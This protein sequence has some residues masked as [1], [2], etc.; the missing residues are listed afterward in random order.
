MRQVNE[1]SE[2]DLLEIV[3]EELF[4]Q[5]SARLGKEPVTMNEDWQT[6]A[7]R[8]TVYKQFGDCILGTRPHTFFIS[9]ILDYSYEILIFPV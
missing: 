8:T 9:W 4:E 6:V 5:P 7:I 2:G 3:Q 1:M